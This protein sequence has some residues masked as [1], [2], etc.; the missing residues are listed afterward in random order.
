MVARMWTAAGILLCILI[1]VYLAIVARRAVDQEL[2]D[3]PTPSR[4]DTEDGVPS[5]APTPSDDLERGRP[6]AESPF[7]S[8]HLISVETGL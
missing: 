4:E 8:H 2:D 1:F 3:E 5:L 6:M 7:R